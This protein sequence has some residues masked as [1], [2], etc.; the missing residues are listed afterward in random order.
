M[1]RM[2][3]LSLLLFLVFWNGT[4][5]GQI[6]II[7]SSLNELM[8]TPESMNRL[9][10]S[11]SG[12]IQSIRIEAELI[13]SED[14]ETL[15]KTES[16]VIPVKKGINSINPTDNFFELQRF[17]VSD[18]SN[19]VRTQ[20][21]LPSG[22]FEYCNRIYTVDGEYFEKEYCKDFFE[23]VNEFLR[24]VS[25][26]DGDTIDTSLPILNWTTSAIQEMKLGTKDY[27]L[28]L[29]EKG[30]DESA[31]YALNVNPSIFLENKMKVM[32]IPYPLS[33]PKLLPNMSYAWRV[34]ALV[35]N[36]V[37][38]ETETWF[39]VIRGEVEEKSLKYAV[40]RERLGGS[41]YEVIDGKIFFAFDET[42]SGS[43]EFP[44]CE[45]ISDLGEVVQ[46]PLEFDS[47]INPN[48]DMVAENQ[49]LGTVQG[50]NK[51]LLDITKSALKPGIYTL[52]VWNFKGEL[53]KLKF[54]IKG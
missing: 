38:D 3:Q 8:V 27:R 37:V 18:I 36:E 21:K 51:Y 48:S 24:L 33:A 4:L 26:S 22:M 16:Q 35:D 46:N 39:F 5:F 12:D 13:N 29:S 50:T 1:K 23:V 28:L 45:I 43:T 31:E 30:E 25:P 54:R 7:N 11:I 19:Y 40:L 32:S 52:E 2:N 14:S 15:I 44:R 53:K 20:R 42:Y 34:E 10:I 17:G 47:D 6:Q 9:V 49:V 41:T